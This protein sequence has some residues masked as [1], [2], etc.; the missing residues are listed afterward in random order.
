MDLKRRQLMVVSALL[1]G[2][3]VAYV[4]AYTSVV[5][6][7]TMQQRFDRSWDAATGAMADQGLSITSQDRSAGMVQGQRGGITIITTLDTLADGSIQVK[8]ASRGDDSKDPGLMRRV[9]DSFDRRM[10]M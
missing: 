7:P 10:G 1:L 9:S 5:S 3:C 8:F 6:Q 4:P 2:S